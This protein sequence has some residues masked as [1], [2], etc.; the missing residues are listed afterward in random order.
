MLGAILHFRRQDS[1]EIRTQSIKS[2]LR[3]SGI[4]IVAV[5]YNL[6]APMGLM[7]AVHDGLNSRRFLLRTNDSEWGVTLRSRLLS[8]RRVCSILEMLL[9]YGCRDPQATVQHDGTPLS[10]PFC[11]CPILKTQN[12]AAA[13]KPKLLTSQ[14]PNLLTSQ[15]PDFPTSQPYN[16]VTFQTST[17]PNFI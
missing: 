6:I 5:C 8:W 1:F 14:L 12:D 3:G 9:P 15:P 16:F 17:P 10:S 4:H 7:L 13:N 11:K 2:P